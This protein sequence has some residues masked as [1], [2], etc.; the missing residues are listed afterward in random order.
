MDVVVDDGNAIRT[1]RARVRSGGGDVIV[2]AEAH[3][4]IAFGVVARRP[5][6]RERRPMPPAHHPRHRLDRRASG[7]KRDLMRFRRR[8]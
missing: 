1:E 4:A 8:V 7:E 2:E 3:G 5:H 6:H